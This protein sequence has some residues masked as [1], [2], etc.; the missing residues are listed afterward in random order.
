[1]LRWAWRKYPCAVEPLRLARLASE[2]PSRHVLLE[3]VEKNLH[4]VETGSAPF[5]ETALPSL[6]QVR[7][8]AKEGEPLFAE[9]CIAAALVCARNH[10][11]ILGSPEPDGLGNSD[12]ITWYDRTVMEAPELRAILEFKIKARNEGYSDVVTS[13][14][15]LGRE[16]LRRLRNRLRWEMRE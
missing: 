9:H 3:S 10:A 13:V 11:R 2:R 4:Q 5:T 15:M 1:M 7:W 12:F 16:Y 14:P 8:T 6:S